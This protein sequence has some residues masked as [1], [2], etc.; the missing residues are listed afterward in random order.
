MRLRRLTISHR[1]DG[2][3]LSLAANDQRTLDS[4]L[5]RHEA[6]LTFQPSFEGLRGHV[7]ASQGYGSALVPWK[8]CDDLAAFCKSSM[9]SGDSARVIVVPAEGTVAILQLG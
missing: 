9:P 4:S 6:S 3:E 8:I 2:V 1:G 5:S 7:Q